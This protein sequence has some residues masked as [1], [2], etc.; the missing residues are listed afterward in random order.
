M[1]LQV[2][3]AGFG[4]TGT[5]SLKVA[6]EQLGFSK[7][8]H[9][10][11][12]MMSSPQVPLWQA[13]CDGD[14]VSW[15]EVFEGFQASCDWPSCRYWE[16]LHHHY[17]EAKI[18]LTVRDEVRWFESVSETIYPASFLLP[19]WLEWLVPPFARLNK[20]IVATVWDGVFDG[21][22]EDREHSLQIY[23]DHIAYVKAT[24]PSDQLLV[25][26]AKEGW[27]PLCDFLKVPVPENDYPHLN[28]AAQIRRMILGVRARGWLA[29]AGLLSGLAT[30]LIRALS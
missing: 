29:L 3:G 24:A 9:M 11:E 23:R 16:R 10:D 4:R 6:L 30:L 15:D 22:F 20:M 25:F 7:C 14:D 12:V 8:H 18:I 27:A 2:I 26:E 1:A 19:R 5:T 13:L 17:P 28:D 21:R